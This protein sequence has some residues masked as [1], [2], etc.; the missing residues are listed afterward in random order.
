VRITFEVISADLRTVAVLLEALTTLD[1]VWLDERPQTPRLYESGVRYEPEDGS[2]LWPV[3]PIVLARG[4]GNCD[5]LA[6]WRA[7][8][9]RHDGHTDAIAFPVRV[10]SAPNVV[11]CLVSRDRS[12]RHI[13]DP[14]ARLGM[15]PIPPRELARV[16]EE[17]R[18]W[19]SR[20]CRSWSLAALSSR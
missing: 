13:E 12:G 15:P 9:L 7:A 8:E 19:L 18:Q 4:F 2:E 10:P 3:I 11:H 20:S 6:A 16:V 1:L 17:H 14:S 5:H